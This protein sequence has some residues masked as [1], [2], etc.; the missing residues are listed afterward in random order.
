MIIYD[1]QSYRMRCD[2]CDVHMPVDEG[3]ERPSPRVKKMLT[4]R[5]ESAARRAGWT[6]SEYLPKHL[7]ARCAPAYAEVRV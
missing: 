7:C 1:R 3:A 5:L 4:P 6:V 2:C